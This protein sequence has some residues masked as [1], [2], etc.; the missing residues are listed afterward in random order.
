MKTTRRELLKLGG[1]VAGTATLFG[2]TGCNF[3]NSGSSGDGTSSGAKAITVMGAQFPTLDPQIVGEGM[4]I[5]VQ[6]IF[7]GLVNQTDDGT[8]VQPGQAEK[9]SMS[10]DGLTYT[11]TLR[12]GL[13]WSDGSPL[14]SDDFMF[15]YERLLTPQAAGA[16]VTLGANSYVSSTNIK[17]ATQFLAGSVTD[18]SQVGIKATDE[19]TLEFTLASP[20]PGF[21]MGLAHPSMLPLPRKLLEAEPQ[22]W[23]KADKIISNGPFKVTGLTDNVRLDLAKNDKYWD[24][25]KVGI[26]TIVL[27]QRASNDTSLVPFESG[28]VDV[29]QVGDPAGLIRFNQDPKLKP[30]LKAAKPGTIAYLALM[31]SKNETLSDPRIRQALSLAMGRD[32]I[33][34]AIPGN[35]PTGSLVPQSVPGWD[36]SDAIT[37]DVDKAKQLLAD[38]GFPDGKGLPPIILL[39]SSDQPLLPPMVANW[40][41]NLGVEAKIDAV[42]AGVYVKKR[43]AMNA[44]DYIGFYFGTFGSELTWAKWVASLWSPTFAKPFSLNAADFEQYL[45][46]QSDKSVKSSQLNQFADQRC[47]AEVKEF[48]RLTTEAMAQTEPDAATAAFKKAAKAREETYL[49]LP[50][51]MSSYRLAVNDRVT[52]FNPRPTGEKYY[53]KT[54]GVSA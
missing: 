9:W 37:E 36:S 29:L 14:T 15:A 19:K 22:D 44:D 28:E 38:A 23:E 25:A 53:F 39:A 48:D 26:D 6:G 7:E 17:N 16:G 3:Q 42:E 13:Q 24:N 11:F 50:I 49:F 30:Q 33:A 2:L 47:S 5:D 45:A 1:A 21:L 54:L 18:F 27:R 46:M 10:D 40:K 20:N 34:P 35:E 51:T 8:D 52:G 41:K 31:H 43:T 12:D 4:W 32:S